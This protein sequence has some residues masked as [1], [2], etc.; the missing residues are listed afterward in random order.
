MQKL[1]LRQ[2]LTQKLSPQQIQ[3]IKLLQVPVAELRARVEQEL[4]VNPV[5]EEGMDDYQEQTE[6]T[7]EREE[8]TEDYDD[9]PDGSVENDFNIEDYLRDDDVGGYRMEGDG[10]GIQEDR[11]MPLADNDS[12]IDSLFTQLGYLKL[13]E[14]KQAIGQ[15]LIGS[16][17]EDGYIRREMDSIANDLAF[18]QNIHVTAEEVEQV[19]LMIQQFDPPGI[20]AR[21]LQECLVLQLERRLHEGEAV[22]I[23]L[24]IVEDQFEEFTKKHYDKIER[25]LDLEDHDLFKQAVNIITHLNP[26]PGESSLGGGTA[27]YVIPDFIVTTSGGKIDLSLNN[28]NAPDLKVSRTYSNMLETLAKRPK[29]TAEEK[30]TINF[31][32]D[33]IDSARWFIDAL[34]QRQNT[35]LKTMQAIID[36]Q[37]EY[38]LEGDESKLRPMILKDIAERIGMDISTVSRVANSKYVQTEGGVFALKYFFSEGIQTEG[39]EDVS[40]R[41]IK[42]YLR[43]QIDAEDKSKPLSDDKLEELLGARGF[44]IARRTVAKYREQ[45]N[46]P[47]ARLRREL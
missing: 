21:T 39:G 23:A 16:I 31:V 33:K 45:L 43:E 14:Q 41:E 4:E 40:N 29:K 19:L 46:I 36:Y 47:V 18:S 20:A 24:Q 28:R 17:D 5:L 37:K 22:E 38:F 1:G 25:R 2:S 30:E 11:D 12:L 34:K 10:P 26:K 32:K 13:D 6:D 44:N 8:T 7:P 15:Q 9:G 42:Q 3:F 35:L 27:Q